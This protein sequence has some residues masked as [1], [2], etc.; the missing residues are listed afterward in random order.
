MKRRRFVLTALATSLVVNVA[1]GQETKR[2]AKGFKVNAEEG[3]LH[4]HIQLTGVNVNI[5]DVKISGADTNGDL[6]IF[7]QTGL[8]PKRGTP[9]HVH[10]FQDE[11]FYVTEGEYHFEVGRVRYKL[12]V[13]ESI[14]LPRKVPHSW[15]QVSDR[16]KMI[17]T[18][19]PAGKLEQFFV[20]MSKFKSAP[21]EEQ[22]TKI[23]EDHEMSVVGPPIK[24]E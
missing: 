5:L 8:S 16:G 11:I 19:Q 10:H 1:K 17:V 20:E 13:G 14:F 24:I 4:G 3:R 22:V 6:A 15:V 18:L 21:T 12:K 7:E 23:F 9:M 2:N